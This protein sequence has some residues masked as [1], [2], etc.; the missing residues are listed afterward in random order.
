MP[1][2]LGAQL[3]HCLDRAVTT[4]CPC[5]GMELNSMGQSWVFCDDSG[6]KVRLFSVRVLSPDGRGS[7]WRCP[8]AWC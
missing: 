4:V 1:V 6:L 3:V 7:R 8:A 5:E 2:F